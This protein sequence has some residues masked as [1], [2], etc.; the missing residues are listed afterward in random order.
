MNV[1]HEMRKPVLIILLLLAGMM[2]KA[3]AVHY[4]SC[5]EVTGS[6][7]VSLSWHAPCTQSEFVK[8]EVYHTTMANPGSFSLLDTIFDYGTT[9]YL[10]SPATANQQSNLYY[11][12]TV[13]NSTDTMVSDTIRTM[14]LTVDNSN[15]YLAVLDWNAMREP[16][17]A[18]S[19]DRYNVFSHNSSG[20]FTQVGSTT[21]KHFD[22][23]VLVCWDTLFFRIEIIDDSGCISRSNIFSAVFRDTEPPPIPGLDSVSINPNT[24]DVILGWNESS[25][26]DARG[27]VI[28]KVLPSINDTLDF[29]FGKE[30]ITYIDRSFDPCTETRS[31]ALASM[32]SC[33]NISPG[34]YD[35][36]QRTILFNE[37]DFDPCLL[38]NTL[39][40]TPYINMNPPL[41]GYRVYLSIDGDPFALLSILTANNTTF[42]H[43]GL[44]PGHRY[45]YF[46]R[47]FSSGNTVT[48][49]SCYRELTTWQYRQPVE[50]DMA[51]ASV[52]DNEGVALTLWPD[53][54]AFVPQMM[55]YRSSEASGP[56]YLID[57][58]PLSGEEEAYFDDLTAEVNQRSYYYRTS[59]IDSCGN[60]VLPSGEYR[61]IFLQG[62]KSGSQ[63][64]ELSWN[65]FGGWPSGVSEYI[66]L[67][68]LDDGGYSQAGSVAGSVQT[69][70]DDVATLQGDF[71]S[72]S[73]IVQAVHAADVR[74]SYSNS[75]TFDYQPNIYLPNAFT[76]GGLNPEFRPVGT[77]AQFEEYRMDIFSRWGEMIF[78]S[79]DFGRGWDGMLN[80]SPAPAGVYVCLVSY[81][82]GT[83]ETNTIKSTFVLIR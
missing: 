42:L 69:Y 68:A 73:Y 82:S 59:L 45:E 51:N 55:I 38:E 72:L 47:A 71:S 22:V 30:N 7:D 56:W 75:I 17:L 10:H 32:D 13:T 77:F 43:E 79:E 76:P 65:A 24:G 2:S 78:S 50:N 74:T 49:T 60:E 4:F 54:S 8:Y 83:G 67:R 18:V 16:L 36:P 66:I 27:Y 11:I 46:I 80:G 34:S 21:D 26:A 37:V 14:H 28:Y 52:F 6:G 15:A 23:P 57:S 25:A 39:S 29:V 40:W 33:G 35:I 5:L 64:N 62:E 1:N 12:A 53:N 3:Q 31:Y 58:L 9:A 19:D 70:T 61:T 63:T 48:S 20:N 44:L 81:R 41:A